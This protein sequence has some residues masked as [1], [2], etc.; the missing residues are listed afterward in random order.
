MAAAA[1]FSGRGVRGMPPGMR[2]RL[3]RRATAAVAAA[4][5]VTAGVAASAPAGSAPPGAGVLLAVGSD[6]IAGTMRQIRVTEAQLQTADAL[7]GALTQR[8]TQMAADLASAK[9]QVSRLGAEVKKAEADVASTVKERKKAQKALSEVTAARDSASAEFAAAQ[10]DLSA[11]QDRLDE[12]SSAADKAARSVRSAEKKVL[13]A[14]SGSKASRSAFTKW[15]MAAIADR[16]AQSRESLAED[17]AADGLVGVAAAQ[18][19]LAEADLARAS[20]A[21]V[22]SKTKRAARKAAV[23][24]DEVTADR[25]AAKEDVAALRPE[26]KEVKAAQK[27]AERVRGQLQSRLALLQQQ[28]WEITHNLAG[29]AKVEASGAR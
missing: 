27:A 12:V 7:V 17:R 22:R 15:Q 13:K 29:D 21:T 10:Q 25:A 5:L 16:A 23:R 3:I 11:A 18:A 26:L 9:E 6:S 20:A 28:A 24:L 4:A 14:K 19:I 8:R 1:R 2:L